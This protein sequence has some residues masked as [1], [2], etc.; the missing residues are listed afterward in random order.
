MS[1]FFYATT[2]IEPHH[3]ELEAFA[4]STGV[5]R[6]ATERAETCTREEKI[7]LVDLSSDLHWEELGH[8]HEGKPALRIALIKVKMHLAGLTYEDPLSRVLR[9]SLQIAGDVNG[10]TF[11]GCSDGC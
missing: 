6:L 8:Y 11:G 1:N 7:A 5:A 3:Q 10:G 4:I 9:G 2:S